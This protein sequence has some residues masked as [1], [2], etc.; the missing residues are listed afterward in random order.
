M[1]V[2]QFPTNPAP[3]HTDDSMIIDQLLRLYAKGLQTRRQFDFG[4]TYILS[5][6]GATSITAN[7]YTLRR[8]LDILTRTGRR[9]TIRFSIPE[10]CGKCPKCG[11][12]GGYV[13]GKAILYCCG[14][15]Y[16]TK[17]LALVKESV[18]ISK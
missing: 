18:G 8:G 16:R 11:G 2:H 12:T 14:N 4:V 15:L 5:S 17:K 6:A 13:A 10:Q 1:K 3:Q 7:N 9:P